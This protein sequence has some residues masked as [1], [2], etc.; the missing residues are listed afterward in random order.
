MGDKDDLLRPEDLAELLGWNVGS[1]R[2]ALL[3]G[4]LPGAKIGRRWY[5]RR[6]DLDAMI[7]QQVQERAKRRQAAQAEAQAWLRDLEES[8]AERAKKREGEE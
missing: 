1:V 2:H 5:T 4:R 8:E 7:E 3:A 6:S